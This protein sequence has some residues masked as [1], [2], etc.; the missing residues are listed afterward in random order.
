[1]YVA[2]WRGNV[3]VVRILLSAGANIEAED[4]WGNTIL[5]QSTNKRVIQILKQ[6][7]QEQE[8]TS[9]WDSIF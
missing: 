7:E 9:W 6:R 5:E 8:T 2:S 3:Q 4:K 1:M